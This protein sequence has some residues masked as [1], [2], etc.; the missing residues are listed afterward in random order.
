LHA[1][2]WWV[3]ALCFI[4][5]FFTVMDLGI[6]VV[7][8]PSIGRVLHSGPDQVQW[9]VSGY[10]L[11]FGIVPTIAGRLGD[12]F[13]QRPLLAVGICGFLAFSVVIGLAPNAML[14]VV[15]RLLQGATGGLIQPQVVGLVH[16]M[17]SDARRGTAFSLIGLATATAAAAG[18]A[19]GGLILVAGGPTLGWRLIFFI[20]VPLCLTALVLCLSLVP[21]SVRERPSGRL[22]VRGIALLSV[23][24]F[25]LLFPA[26]ELNSHRDY[27]LP[28]IFIAA[29]VI[30]TLLYRWEAGG[31][32]R[33]SSPL[34]DVGLFRITSYVNGVGIAF[35]YS[36]GYLAAPLLLT[37]F[38]QEGL[39]YSPLA[40]GLA[41][42]PVA[43]GAAVSAPLGGLL[44][45]RVGRRLV[46]AGLSL[47]IAGTAGAAVS[48]LIV[49]GLAPQH[50][51]IALAVPL[52]VAG[53]GGGWVMHP[54]QAL[55]L[56]NIDAAHGSAAGGLIQAGQ[57]LGGALGTAISSTVFYIL[58][59]LSAGHAAHG[60]A[61]LYAH[62]FVGGSSV[63]LLVSVG[64]LLLAIRDARQRR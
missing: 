41:A 62:A 21:R 64:A 59:S 28:V 60:R 53:I 33:T 10:A 7:A 18:P 30:L 25:G 57:R 47:F 35:L 13:G 43:V 58:V 14:L 61:R 2:R 37:L 56:E 3:L 9:V 49:S 5:T 6:V 50:V 54:N 46:V 22:D 8:L 48:A 44:L 29:V 26:I 40:A 63:L 17:F 12:D 24:L 32:R 34:V 20:N 11:T 45:R 55:T 27:R 4:C 31:A 1:K 19:L 42:L 23:G 15:G 52:L 36:A 39:D 38:L 16:T 51:G